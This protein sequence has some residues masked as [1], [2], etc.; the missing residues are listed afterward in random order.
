MG[1]SPF[2]DRQF[3]VYLALAASLP[4]MHFYLGKS[5]TISSSLI[6][7]AMGLLWFTWFIA[8][9]LQSEIRFRDASV[10]LFSYCVFLFVALSE[11]LMNGGAVWLTKKRGEKWLKEIDYLYL[12]LGSVGLFISVGQMTLVS[13]KLSLPGTIGPLALATALTLRIV[14]TRAE[15]GG[16]NKL[17]TAGAGSDPTLL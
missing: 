14:K 7:L 8:L 13:D 2:T 17:P 6:L 11:L 3:Y 15:I 4:L 10:G 5:K 12:G 1:D 16:W 9:G